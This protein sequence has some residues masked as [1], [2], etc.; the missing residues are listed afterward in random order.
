MFNNA[1]IRDTD[2]FLNLIKTMSTRIP[3]YNKVALHV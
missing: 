1:L 2:L 3:T